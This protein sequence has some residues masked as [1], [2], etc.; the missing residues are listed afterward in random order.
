MIVNLP[1]EEEI[2][3]AAA[4]LNQAKEENTTEDKLVENSFEPQN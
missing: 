3:D 1:T 2:A 4:C